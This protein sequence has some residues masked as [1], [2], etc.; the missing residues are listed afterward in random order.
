MGTYKESEYY[1]EIY[2]KSEVYNLSNIQKSPYYEVWKQCIRLI[3]K[4]EKIVDFGCG[5]GLFAKL[6]IMNGRN[7][8][9]GYDFSEVA[10]KK[11]KETNKAVEVITKSKAKD[12]EDTKQILDI[13]DRFFVANITDAK[14]YKQNEFDVCVFIEVAEHLQNDLLVFKNIPELTKVI[15]TVPNYDSA[16]HVRQF[17][18]INEAI[19]YYRPLFFIKEEQCQTVVINEQTKSEIYILSFQKKWDIM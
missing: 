7:Y 12:G 1:D 19:E 10:I 4:K 14:I 2:A 6:C 9:T 5:N 3:S 15:I 13:S 8:I 18:D 16:S 11:A 17:K